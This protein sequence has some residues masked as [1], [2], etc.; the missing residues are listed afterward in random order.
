M[1]GRWALLPDLEP[2]P[3]RR[4]H[5]SAEAL[6]ERHGVVTRG[7]VMAEGITGGFAAV[8]PVLGA[9]EERGAARRGYF[10]EG[11]GGAQFCLPA[12]LG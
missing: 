12:A 11:L 4:A 5:A 2:D 7:A 9:L 6:L 8:Y 10:V 3:T 1:A